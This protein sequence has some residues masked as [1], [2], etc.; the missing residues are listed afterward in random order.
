MVWISAD[1]A[2]WV[3]GAGDFADVV[4]EGVAASP[5]GRSAG[6]MAF[7]QRSD[8]RWAVWTS[9]E[10]ATWTEADA[11]GTGEGAF[12]RA[13]ATSRGFLL[14]GSEMG[15][16]G[17]R[18][19]LWSSTNGTQWSIVAADSEALRLPP[20]VVSEEITSFAERQAARSW[21]SGQYR[22]AA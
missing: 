9:H 6:L 12:L 21:Q 1:G 2:S 5:A 4:I 8:G 11:P 18:L 10:G 13:Y 7:G 14:A 22:G 20:G 16:G 19:R 15:V 3:T 17:S